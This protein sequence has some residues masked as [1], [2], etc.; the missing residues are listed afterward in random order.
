MHHRLALHLV[1]A[2]LLLGHEGH[3]HCN[4]PPI[5]TGSVEDPR[6]DRAVGT[7]GTAI[8]VLGQHHVVGLHAVDHRISARRSQGVKHDHALVTFGQQALVALHR[9]RGVVLGLALLISQL[10]AIDT[11][12][13]DIHIVQVIDDAAVIAGTHRGVRA[14]PATRNAEILL[15]CLGHHGAR[16]G[17]CESQSCREQ[18]AQDHATNR[19]VSHV[20]V[21]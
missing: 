16:S 21:S 15:L 11:A 5:V 6:P 1:D 20:D 18:A 2:T 4:L 12:E 19:V 9:T 13:L 17:G 3:L 7:V 14:D 8:A 10:D